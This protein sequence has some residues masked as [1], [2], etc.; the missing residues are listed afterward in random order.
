[1]G[2]FRGT[3]L[4]GL[5]EMS[6]VKLDADSCAVRRTPGCVFACH[7]ATFAGGAGQPLRCAMNRSYLNRNL[8]MLKSE[9][10]KSK[11]LKSNLSKFGSSLRSSLRPL[12]SKLVMRTRHAGIAALCLWAAFLALSAAASAQN[13]TLQASSFSPDAVPP[14]GTSSS[15]ITVGTVN[16]FSGTVDLGCQVTS[17]QATTDPPACTVSP[18]TVTPPAS[19]SATITTTGETSSVGYSITITGTAS[20]GTQT[21]QPLSL[22]VLAVTQQFT[23]T[24]E[25]AVVPNSVPA[26]SGGEGTIT[27]NPIN[28]Y[29]SPPGTPGV[30][31]SCATITPLVTIPPVCS[32]SPPAVMVNGTPV[33]STITISTFGPVT[34]GAVAHPRSFYALWMPL[35]MLA[36]VGL[37]GAVGG[38]RSRKACVLLALF[39]ISGAL[40]L[41][42]ACGNTTTSTTTPNGVTPNNSYTFTLMGVDS[43]GVSSSNT[44][45]TT[46]ANPTVSLSVTTPAN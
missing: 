31:L 6:A 22:T 34:T 40:F 26:G 20:T 19:A 27:V 41:M 42:P 29:I 43:D 12:K 7:R 9:S 16:G 10:L 30:T 32:F 13:F 44:G 39:V 4:R 25:K 23:I 37:G 8:L 28:G 2:R 21:T 45:S 38:K 46:T 11:R 36:L 18:A 1:V 17:T 24:V 35:P 33:T 5:W 14:G 15:N 3:G